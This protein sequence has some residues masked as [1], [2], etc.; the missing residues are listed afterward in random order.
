ML[1]VHVLDKYDNNP[2]K[3]WYL[4]CAC[5]LFKTRYISYLPRNSLYFIEGNAD[6]GNRVNISRDYTLRDNISAP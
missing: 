1:D 2:I 5:I 4:S 3:I 6:S